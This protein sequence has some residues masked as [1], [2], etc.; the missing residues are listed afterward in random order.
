MTLDEATVHSIFAAYGNIKSCKFMA[1]AG[2]AIIEFQSQDEAQWIVENLNGNIAQGLDTPVQCKFAN[3]PGGKGK[4]WAPEGKGKGGG[5]RWEPYGG[6]SWDGGKG[7]G[8]WGGGKSGGW[9]SG[10]GGGK[11]VKGGGIAVLKK[12][13]QYAGAL[14]GGKWS[15]DQ[16]ALFVS[17]LPPDTTSC[18]LYEIFAPFGA[19][20]SGGAWAMPREDGSC[21]G[22]GFINYLDEASCHNALNTLNGTMMPDGTTLRVMPKGQRGERSE[23]K[24]KGKDA[25]G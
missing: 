25:P 9:D 5:G 4:E 19:M 12:G 24:G 13:L 3:A 20:P 6:G 16:N 18:D 8:S 23:T 21:K 15:N 14:P 2:Q 17:G 11:S 7:G 1:G 10:K 22:I